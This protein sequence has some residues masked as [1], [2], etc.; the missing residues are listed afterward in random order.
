MARTVVSLL[1]L[2]CLLTLAFVPSAFSQDP[3]ALT[4]HQD[5]VST[6]AYS[7]DGNLIVTGS[8]DRTLRVFQA[9]D[10]AELRVLDGHLGQVLSVAVSADG[11]RVLSGSRDA[12]VKLW[13]LYIPT[14]LNRYEG[15]TGP[16]RVVQISADGAWFVTAGDDQLAKIWNR[17]D[18][19]LLHTLTGH[20]AKITQ[21][22]IKPDGTQIAT[23]DEAG[24]VQLWDPKT[25]TAV[26]HIGAHTAAITGLSYHPT[27]ASLLTSAADGTA[28]LWTLPTSVPA[29]L[30]PQ[31]GA[32]TQVISVQ[33]GKQVVT[34]TSDGKVQL[35]T[36]TAAAPTARAFAGHVGA[37]QSMVLSADA[38]LL[39][40]GNET[41][42]IRLW[43]VADGADRLS[44]MGHT[45]PVHALAVNATS[46]KLASAGED[47][48]VRLW[49]LP[50]AASPFVGHTMPVQ[51][52]ATSADGK[53]IATGSAD[54]TVRIWNA[55]DQSVAQTLPGHTATVGAVR[56]RTDNMQLASA[57]ES[58]AIQLWNVADGKPQGTFH[59]PAAPVTD[60]A[61]L[62]DGKT[63]LSSSDAGT[64]TWWQLPSLPAKPLAGH[65]TAV[66]H[67]AFS[68]DGKLAV[69]GG[70]DGSLRLFD[71]TSGQAARALTSTRGPV[72]ALALAPQ[73]VAAGYAEGIIE[74]WNPT[75]GT[76][77]GAVMTPATTITDLAFHPQGKQLASADEAG[78][79]RIWN[80]PTP[81]QT[82]P[83][84]AMTVTAATYSGDG[85]LVALAGTAG[86]RPT[87]MV[88]DT[89][90]GTLKSTQL[91]HTSTITTLAFS[92]D[93]TKLVSGSADKTVR[94]WNLATPNAAEAYLYEGHTAAITAVA[95]STNGAQVF[96]AATDNSLKQWTT[97]DGTDVRDLAGHTAAIRS[98][99]L[100]GNTLVSA[101]ADKTVRLWNPANGALLRSLPHTVAPTVAIVS[102]DGKLIATGGDGNAVKLFNAANGALVATLTGHAAPA[103]SL[104]FH[105]DS[106]RLISCATDGVRSWSATGEPLE[107][108]PAEAIRAVAWSAQT[109]VLGADTK[110][111]LH[112]IT[113]TFVNAFTGHTGPVTG[114]AFS[115]DGSTL[116]SGGDDKTVRRWTTAD[117]KQVGSYTGPSAA[118]TS[119]SLSGDG[120][121]LVAGSVDKNVYTWP[122][123]AA[124][125]TPVP[126]ASTFVHPGPVR[127][128]SAGPDGTRIA[129][130]GDDHAIT[131]WSTADGNVLERL[132]HHT[133]PVL[134]VALAADNQTLLSGSADKTAVVSSVA[135]IRV[136]AAAE[137][138]IV[139][140]SLSAD[141]TTAATASAD[142]R[143]VVWNTA[144]GKLL[145]ESTTGA[146]APTAVALH[147]DKSQLAI[148]LADMKLNLLPLTAQGLGTAVTVTLPAAATDLAYHAESGKL[149]VTCADKQLRVFASSTGTLLEQIAMTDVASN[150]AFSTTGDTV[151][152]SIA[153]TAVR[154]P[155]A[156]EQL[157][158]A[159]E[160]PVQCVTFHADGTTVIS[161]GKDKTVRMFQLTDGS[162]TRSFAGA[163]DAI[164]TL[165]LSANGKLLAAGVADKS[166]L[167]WD[168]TV[169]ATANQPTAATATLPQPAVIRDISIDEEATRIA[170]GGDDGI[171]RV[172]DVSTSQE[173]ERFVGHEGAIASVS[174]AQDQ[175][176][177][178]SGG[179]DKTPRVWSVS[180]DRLVVADETR[181]GD[182][183]F[184]GD[185]STFAT[186]GTG[187][188]QIKIWDLEGTATKQL[189]G[190]KGPAE[191]L[192]ISP[193]G[194]QIA[195]A[196]PEGVAYVWTLADGMLAQT[197]ES[198]AV[199]NDLDFSPQNAQLALAG[200]D[201]HLRVYAVADGSLL[202]DQTSTAPVA[203]VQFAPEGRE[204][205]TASNDHFVDLWAYASP[206]EVSSLAGHPGGTYSVA[207]SPDGTQ[208]VSSGA[209]QTVRLWDLATGEAKSLA[210]HTGSVY[211][212][213]FDSEGKQI[214]TASADG[215][216]KIWNA[217]N[218][219]V[220]KSFALPVA[221]GETALPL[222]DAVLSPN[223]QQVIAT[224]SAK[225]IY[226][227]TVAN[228]QLG[229][230]ITGHQDAVYKLAFTADQS[231][232]VSIGHAG[233]LH[234]WNPANGQAIGTSQLPSVTYS[235][236]ISPTEAKAVVVGADKKAY[237]VSVP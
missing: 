196:G 48:T 155:L 212:A 51:A 69:T 2:A 164:T 209:D 167:T 11:R 213:R 94:V 14:P 66:S 197:I 112:T 54:K 83:G 130:G 135:A 181:V 202:Q 177:V 139:G 15:H 231:K 193:D 163:A 160:G 114:L 179:A 136:L 9:A 175:K 29:P 95:F 78:T 63:M 121:S 145:H 109:T 123:A 75:D 203:S 7:P 46:D 208:A 62:P 3:L 140:L 233:H 228:G 60:I 45:G 8:F 147:P 204:L 227:W 226:V 211:S 67:V 41:G 221:E 210:G 126:A 230:T 25:G 190:G 34:G 84:S 91:G 188:A 166:L 49:R 86:G 57:D 96:S 17:A 115:P 10:G 77:L 158:S 59:G 205:I 151:V 198:E 82:L 214:V 183:L 27:T 159:H 44:L 61:Y 224:G 85:T 218:G 116:F 154:Q 19:M 172:L 89:A 161:G 150:V 1:P 143:I 100:V 92:S 153:N 21:A 189:T 5:A 206:T 171:L 134:D 152:A 178:F 157:I 129:S 111:G 132:L 26:A 6:A 199:I 88:R 207:F 70:A 87:I 106:T 229:Q 50:A 35:L 37:V 52:T 118:V 79:I 56:F 36:L 47:G 101:S 32:I 97:A 237:V 23:G 65:T 104:A 182:A 184:L 20:E 117:G 137:A 192:A 176:T 146:A 220:V 187:P 225:A 234:S 168:L 76:E 72:T 73:A 90:Q 33:D 24:L 38:T 71:P 22:S 107:R 142:K 144:D 105:A 120:K 119:L 43:N 124:T 98:L 113:P 174:F 222:F 169:A 122:V 223:G 215:T 194:T 170:T 58:G 12:T 149:G 30:P 4:G 39:A 131:V 42:A 102:P 191:T 236:A 103:T 99:H 195:A 64:L 235:A 127:S 128:V 200:A 141:G 93:K 201:N 13:D 68:A 108:F 110:N 74:C 55:A 180:A 148:A 53:W 217:A 156:L 16:V 219:Q 40:S 80:L 133:L 138:A 81:S 31:S 162:Q 185:G 232:L 18:G 125:A 165:S 173:L 28:K 186:S 216:A